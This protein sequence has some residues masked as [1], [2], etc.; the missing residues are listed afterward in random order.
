MLVLLK[1]VIE[2]DK[3]VGAVQ[4]TTPHETRHQSM[5]N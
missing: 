5:K 1:D 4:W 3:E 2:E